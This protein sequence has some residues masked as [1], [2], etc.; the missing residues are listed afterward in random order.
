MKSRID[1]N[2]KIDEIEN[3][4]ILFTI[5]IFYLELLLELRICHFLITFSKNNEQKLVKSKQSTE[6]RNVVIHGVDC[7]YNAKGYALYK[8]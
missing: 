8:L 1:K 7:P 4:A 3:N 2:I 6:E 5:Q